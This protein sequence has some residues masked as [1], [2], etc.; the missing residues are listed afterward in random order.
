MIY[1]HLPREFDYAYR[2]HT[3]TDLD[4]GRCDEVIYASKSLAV[5]KDFARG[6]M[7][8]CSFSPSTATSKATDLGGTW[9]MIPPTTTK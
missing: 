3:H 2:G 1:K 5:A 8:L 6:G 7:G 9:R 4:W